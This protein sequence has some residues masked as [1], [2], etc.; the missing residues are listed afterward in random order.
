M[1]SIIVHRVTYGRQSTLVKD[2]EYVADFWGSP[3]GTKA[4]WNKWA[5]KYKKNVEFKESPKK[6]LFVNQGDYDG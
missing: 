1:D 6:R 2:R 4:E 5:K 3:V